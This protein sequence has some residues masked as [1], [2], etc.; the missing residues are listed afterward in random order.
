MVKAKRIPI[1]LSRRLR[2]LRATLLPMLIFAGAATLTVLL[3]KRQMV[4]P[5]SWGAVEAIRYDLGSH[6]DGTLVWDATGQPELF[7]QVNAGDVVARLD[8]RAVLG[9]MDVVRAENAQ[10]ESQLAA[11]LLEAELDQGDRHYQRK[12]DA[13]R[14]ALDIERMKLELLDRDALIAADRIDKQRR[15]EKVKLTEEL[16]SKGSQTEF[17]LFTE[18]ARRDVV[19][20][21]IEGNVNAR[22]EANAQLQSAQQRFAAL[23]SVDDPDFEKLLNPIRKGMAVQQ[24]RLRELAT[25]IESLKIRAPITGTITAIYRR[26]GQA[27][28]AGEPI[29]TIAQHESPHI[30]A[31]IR[32]NQR[33][34]PQ[35]DMQVTIRPRRNP[36]L[37]A[38]STIAFVGPQFESVPIHHLANPTVPEVG[39]PVSIELPKDFKLIPGEIVDL[40]FKR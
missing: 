1:P 35:L 24:A 11:T 33:I 13:R 27:V 39:L 4:M 36:S 19:A 25:Q 38:Q 7:Q 15:D 29:M 31:Y 10:L 6:I 20:A 22:K 2:R 21:R 18:R 40:T 28:R 16:V 9:L 23:P 5:N 34:D 17:E 30:V 12:V 3:W 14:L 8:N 26:S 37:V 32:P